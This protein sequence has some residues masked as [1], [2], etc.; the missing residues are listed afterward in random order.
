MD[1]FKN[2]LESLF[3]LGILVNTIVYIPQAI[4]LIRVKHANDISLLTFSAFNIFLL[5]QTIYAYLHQDYHFFWGSLLILSSSLV[6]TGLIVY[7]RI[8]AN[9]IKISWNTMVLLLPLGVVLLLIVCRLITIEMIWI[10]HAINVIY[11]LSFLWTAFSAL[12]QIITLLRTKNSN[13][14]SII[15]FLGFNFIQV[16]TIAHAYFYQEW[17]TLAGVL[18]L[19][20]IYTAL[21][22]LI[23]YYRVKKLKFCA[24][25][26]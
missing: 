23:V 19:L 5:I 21:S 26:P 20:I 24:D 3:A 22:Y 14:L 9:A 12:P 8:K 16:V 18:L 1:L 10:Y 15:T 7:F 2:L 4:K 13:E 11:S 17:L 6:V 25:M